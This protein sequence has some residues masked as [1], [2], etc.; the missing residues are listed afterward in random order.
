LTRLL[1]VDLGER[2]I[3]LAVADSESAEV[4]PLATLRRSSP[5]RDAATVSRVCAEQRIDEIIVGL[6]LNMDGTEGDQ[7]K[8]TREW[9]DQVSR[10]VDRPFAWHDERLSSEAAEA[11]LGRPSR[12]PAGGPPS[13]AARNARRARVDREAAAHL[14]QSELDSR[15]SDERTL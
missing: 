9:V 1:G 15:G 12:G 4:R 6:P 10:G 8:L 11:R 14:L 3:G 5:E 13:V 2:R 7:A